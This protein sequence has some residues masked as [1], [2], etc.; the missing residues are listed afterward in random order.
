MIAP[1]R[2]ACR[3]RVEGDRELEILNASL[4]VLGEVGYDRLTMDAVSKRAKVSK[5]TLY[6]RW[7][8][9]ANLVIDALLAEKEP[10]VPTDTGS[11]RGDLIGTFCG[12]GGLTDSRVV[13]LFGSVLTALARDEEFS[14]EFRRQFLDPKIRLG[15]EI[16]ERAQARGEIR[17]DLDLDV[18]VPALAGIILH[19]LF[20]LNDPPSAD[21]VTRVVDHVIL[22][23]VGIGPPDPSVADTPHE[24]TITSTSR[25]TP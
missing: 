11:L 5:A 12:M 4:E 24:P 14:A 17:D 19:R 10:V 1:L 3:P 16:Y 22:P 21:I 8:G 15:R 2:A 18:I 9:K 7:Q 6:R 20:L 25:T 23:A 13:G